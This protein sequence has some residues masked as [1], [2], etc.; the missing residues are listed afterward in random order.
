MQEYYF[1]EAPK[2]LFGTRFIPCAEISEDNGRESKESVG[3][4][5]RRDV[6]RQVKA[7][8]ALASSQ[9]SIQMIHKKVAYQQG[10]CKFGIGNEI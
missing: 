9:I 3:E 7:T 1:R 4:N 5:R 8:V 10:S 2:N 6:N